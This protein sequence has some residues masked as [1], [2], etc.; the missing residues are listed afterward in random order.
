MKNKN[1]SHKY[2]KKW[3]DAFSQE[4]IRFYG[5]FLSGQEK[6]LLVDPKR[7]K[8]TIGLS[9]EIK[10]E[11]DKRTGAL[12]RPS[13]KNFLDYNVNFALNELF[14]VKRNW[15]KIQKPIIKRLISEVKGTDYHH[16]DDDLYQSGIVDFT[17]AAQNAQMLTH[18]S[19][20]LAA[21]EQD[22]LHITLYSQ[23][24]HQLA[25][26]VDA[27]LLQL[28]TRNGYEG[29][30]FNRNVLYAFKGKNTENIRTLDGFIV[31]DKMYL[32]WNFLKHNSISTF[33]KLNEKFPELLTE[34]TYIQ[35]HFSWFLIKWSDDLLD[36]ILDGIEI[37][38][39]EYCR[40]VFG[41]NAIEA[42]WNCE[43]Y[44][45]AGVY[46]EINEIQDPM[47]LRFGFYD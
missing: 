40:L 27:I 31:Y 2:S 1:S 21:I 4:D 12:F 42:S 8:E 44:F 32:I 19:H 30:K 18:L 14:N 28:L 47:G 35:G 41:E 33:N 43:E 39:K 7:Y 9:D 20:E 46:S 16:I 10:K 13:K 22:N 24:F 15:N 29:D 17:E 3:Y 37:F 23:F 45:L 25:S 38:F 5:V 36:S 34:N 26:Q 11:M 6:L